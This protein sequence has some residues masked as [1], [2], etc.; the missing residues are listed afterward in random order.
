[1]LQT[2]KDQLGTYHEQD[3][4]EAAGSET[5][6]LGELIDTCFGFLRRQLWV[7]VF[8]TVLM[9]AL[10][11][12]VLMVMKPNFNAVT[13]VL[14]DTHRVQL[15]QQQAVT[16]ELIYE[17]SAAMESQLE[18][19]KSEKVALTVIKKLNLTQDPEFVGSVDG[20][21]GG[22]F[23][24]HAQLSESDRA[25]R[26]LGAFEKRL[27]VKR[28][29]ITYVIEIDFQS[30]SAWR[31]AEIANAIADAYIDEQLESRYEATRR[32]ADWLGDRI[33][34][35][36]EEASNSQRAVVQFKAANNI[37]E[38]GSGHGLVE[39]Q[40][41][42]LNSQL[43]IT[44]AQ[45]SEA[46]ARLDRTEEILRSDTDGAMNFG[47]TDILKGEIH[48][49][50]AR[51]RTQYVELANREADWSARYGHNH[52]AAINL[53]NQ[54]REIRGAILEEFQRLAATYKNDVEIA[55][56]R[57]EGLQKELSS[58][59]S[60]SQSADSAQVT[61]RKLESSAQSYQTM[62]DNFLRRYTESVEQQSFPT[63][64]ARV[65]NRAS[66]PQGRNYKKTLVV[67]AAMP[68]IGVFLGLGIGMLRELGD[69]VFRT[70]KQVESRL[71]SSCIALVPVLK[72]DEV[73]DTRSEQG[74]QRSDAAP[75][76]PRT[77]TRNQG[78]ARAV[79]DSPFSRF[80]EAVRSIKVAVDVNGVVKSNKVIGF[81]SALPNEGKSTLATAFGHVIAGAGGRVIL[82]D[83]D[84]RN[85]S[86]SRALTPNANCGFLE[87]VSGKKSIEEAVWKDSATNLAFLPAVFKF[88]LA[89]SHEILA[90]E[91]TKN[92]F[93]RLRNSY[94]YVIVDL[95]PLAPVVDVRAT[96][97]LVDSYLF[98]VEW[99]RTKI[100]VVEHALA[101]AHGVHENVLGV[102]L[103]KVN[104]KLLSRYEGNRASYYHNKYYARYGYVD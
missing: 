17:T 88:R 32:T 102:V 26:A 7:L 33:K 59:V 80:T 95:S 61:L 75:L 60:Q 34:E 57:E 37:V 23:G 50:A 11:V 89:H 18:I 21:Q 41:A 63:T 4:R 77:L 90:S 5:A 96:T 8:P 94:D 103:N 31:A 84:L 66:P 62:Y 20:K 46:Q 98:V 64:D 65:L 83:C 70:G 87:V 51:L 22:W 47:M 100:D 56:Q 6:S 99:G 93:D 49:T 52:L 58:A 35:V 42:E 45:R 79:I 72:D 15:F 97:H 81:T 27:T 30:K 43:A 92:L 82:L 54:M 9:T 2:N 53:R 1:M 71:Q 68:F 13:T 12:A 24:S 14:M 73:K 85:P 44:R 76:A 104:M 48:D 55:R 67:S 19:L 38:T 3:L 16:G 40:L 36:G 25:D 101:G 10:G 29:G 69:R 39:Q 74:G 78:I 86:L 91:A 28:L